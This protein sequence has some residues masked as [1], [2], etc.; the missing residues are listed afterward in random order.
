M[1]QVSRPLPQRA[2][3]GGVLAVATDVV[4]HL[5]PLAGPIA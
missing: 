2:A 3:L 5:E 4:L 1:E